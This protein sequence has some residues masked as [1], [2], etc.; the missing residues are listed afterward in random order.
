MKR[1]TIKVA[2]DAIDRADAEQLGELARALMRRIAATGARIW[3]EPGRAC[4]GAD[5]PRDPCACTAIVSVDEH[6]QHVGPPVGLLVRLPMPAHMPQW[7]QARARWLRAAA[8]EHLRDHDAGDELAARRA[9]DDLV[10]EVDG[11]STLTLDDWR[12]ALADALEGA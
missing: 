1:T 11:A 2:V 4:G 10:A 9:F 12:T 3:H 6:G 5:E 8:V 7:M